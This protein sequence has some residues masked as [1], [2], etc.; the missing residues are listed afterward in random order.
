MAVNTFT[1]QPAEEQTRGVD[2]TGKLPTGVAVSSATVAAT[3]IEAGTDVSA[4]VL[5]S[6][7]ASVA[8]NVASVLMKAG[9]DGKR[10]LIEF[11]ATL[12]NSDILEEDIVMLVRE[13]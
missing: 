13:I 1:K 12:D 10:Y 8:S 11:T 9:T 7:T 6:T 4:T 5:G 2:F 3:D